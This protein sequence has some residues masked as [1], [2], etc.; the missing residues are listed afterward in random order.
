MRGVLIFLIFLISSKTI[1]QNLVKGSVYDPEGNELPEVKILET[2]TNNGTE[3]N[4]K[5]YFELTTMNDASYLSFS[6][7]GF[8]TQSVMV[9]S[10]T[11]LNITLNNDFYN[12]RWLTF[13]TN[14]EFFNSVIGLQISNGVDEEPLIHFEDFQDNILIKV[15]GQSDL[16][17]NYSYGAELGV[18]SLRYIGRT[19]LKYDVLNFENSELFLTDINLTSR[20]RYF[21]N[22]GLIFR[23]GY[24]DLNNQKNFGVGLGFEQVAEKVYFG[25]NSIY[26]FDYFHHQA[27]VQFRIA[28]KNLIS[29]RTVYNRIDNKNLLSVGLNYSFIRNNN[30]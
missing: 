13:G 4:I 20:I 18:Y 17:N 11:T 23:T 29:F 2:G 6:W 27:F 21:R 14:Y 10:D 22:T 7:I 8:K 9:T 26:Y 3:S 1:S 5:G 30:R 25:F 19:T 28:P 24:Q 16:N 12:T 15:H